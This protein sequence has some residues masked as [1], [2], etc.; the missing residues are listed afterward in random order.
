MRARHL[1]TAAVLTLTTAVLT[2]A[3]APAQSSATSA[4]APPTGGRSPEARPAGHTEVPVQGGSARFAT[5]PAL[6]A[7][8]KAQG[9]V[10][11]DV[12]AQGAVTPHHDADGINLRVKGGAVT[13]SGGKVGGELRFADAG[14]ALVHRGTKKVVKIT[15]FTADLGQGALRAR[16][17]GG[18][19]QTV[20]TFTRPGIT[21]SIDTA[22]ATLRMNTGITV[23]AAAA[24]RLNEA[25]GTTGF[26]GGPLLHARIDAAL[27][28]SVDLR[29]ALNLGHRP[30][31]ATGEGRRSAG[32]WEGGEPLAG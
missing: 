29:T 15:G 10:I 12:D 5:P 11:A 20:G 18:P 26:S 6:L 8:L 13:N 21:P 27:D 7:A 25:L 16:I 14:I 24:A 4:T 22:T 32:A 23:T 19:R 2:A 1:A 3:P 17:D 9:V 31:P 28:P 30:A